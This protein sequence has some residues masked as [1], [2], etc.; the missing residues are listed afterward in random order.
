MPNRVDME[1][2]L[3]TLP[4]EGARVGVHPNQPVWWADPGALGITAHL[5]VSPTEFEP[6]TGLCGVAVTPFVVRRT[7]TTLRACGACLLLYAERIRARA[8]DDEDTILPQAV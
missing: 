8:L 7:V 6:T 5:A 2:V 3:K 1:P 4:G